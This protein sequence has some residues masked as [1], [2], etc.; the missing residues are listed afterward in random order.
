MSQYA[1]IQ[2]ETAIATPPRR[3]ARRWWLAGLGVACVGVGGV[4]VFVPGLPTTIFLIIRL[5]VLRPQL[6][7][8]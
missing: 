3:R 2:P 4:G 1:L 7:V 5:V 6:P 8:A